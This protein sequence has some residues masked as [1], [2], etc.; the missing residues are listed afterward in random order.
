LSLSTVNAARILQG[1]QNGGSGEKNLLAFERFDYTALAKTYDT[2]QQTPDSAGTMTAIATGVKTRAG[3]LWLDQRA[4]S[5][6]CTTTHGTELVSILELAA[7]ADMRTGIVTTTRITH[8]TPAALYAKASD[9]DWESDRGLPP[10]AVGGGCRDIARQ[11]MEHNVG[12]GINVILG[13]GR[14]PVMRSDQS[15]PEYPNRKG[16]RLDGRDL[17]RQWRHRHPGGY[18]VWNQGQFDSVST[19]PKR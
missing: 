19:R 9:R 8:A 14:L 1:Q 5:G 12:K 15:D 17:I 10:S 2:N 4:G 6:R 13:G 16:L 7:L 18:Y 11:L 3:V